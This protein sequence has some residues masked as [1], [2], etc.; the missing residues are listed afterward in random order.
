MVSCRIFVFFLSG[1]EVRCDRTSFYM[2]HKFA[3]I[4]KRILINGSFNWTRSAITGNYE[5]VC[6]T[7]SDDMVRP[8]L[9]LFNGLWEAF[10]PRNHLESK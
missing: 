2:H 10:H 3:V 8:Y 7:N 1:I 5:N 9:E 4:D 6:I